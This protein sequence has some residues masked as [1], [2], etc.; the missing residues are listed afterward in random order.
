MSEITPSQ[1]EYVDTSWK[2]RWESVLQT[3]NQVVGQIFTVHGGGIAGVLAFAAS[4]GSSVSVVTSLGAFSL[5]LVLIVVYGVCMYYFEARYFFRFRNAAK[6]FLAGSAEW[7]EFLRRSD[8]PDKYPACE[9]LAWGSGLL[10]ILGVI[11]ALF[12]ILP[13]DPKTAPSLIQAPTAAHPV[14]TSP[15]AIPPVR[16]VLPTAQS[17]NESSGKLQVPR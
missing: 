12:A 10:G 7:N 15:S 2:N 9:Y 3:Q 6:E 11:G 1:R 8:S 14:Q 16:F 17:L 4:K 5:G 13:D